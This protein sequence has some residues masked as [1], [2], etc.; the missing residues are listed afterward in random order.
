VW[1]SNQLD[2]TVSA[3]HTRSKK[4]VT[5]IPVATSPS[6]LLAIDVNTASTGDL[7]LR[8]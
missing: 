8:T 7:S 4:V 2:D 5:T 1:V 3:I 6:D